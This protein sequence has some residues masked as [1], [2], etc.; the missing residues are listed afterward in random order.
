MKSRFPAS[1]PPARCGTRPLPATRRAALPL[2][3]ALPLL[4]GGLML[5]SEPVRAQATSAI[6]I[7]GRM[8]LAVVHYGGRE[9]INRE[10]NLSSRL[11][12][13]GVEDLGGGYSA[14]FIIETGLSGDTGDSTLGSRETSIGLAGPFGKLRLGYMLNPIDDLHHIAGP[15][16]ATN[17]TN[18]NLSGFWANGYSN[19]FTGGS[20]GSTAC[21]QVAG[22]NGNGNSFAFDNRIGN[23]LR[24]DSPAFSGFKFATQYALGEVGTCHAWASSNKLQYTDDKLNAALA[25]QLHH[26][27]RGTGLQD[28]IWMLVVGYQLTPT[29][30]VAG[31]AQT[32]S[33]ANPGSQDLKQ[34][35]FGL[36]WRTNLDKTNLLELAW[37]RAGAGRGMQTPVFSGIFTGS[38]TASDLYV[39]GARHAFS[40]RTELWMQLAQLRNGKRAGYDLGGAGR[41]G[42]AGT[43][44]ARP[45][46]LALGI[47]H[48]F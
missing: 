7:Y 22:P 23:A 14:Q 36:N 34:N 19:M 47:K 4:A 16:Y 33:Y 46:A 37:Y 12:I 44:A 38:D 18:D 15:G 45:H 29:H 35:G 10:N 48:D 8:N 1:I 9:S 25:Y 41:A 30:Y 39:L 27:V 13:K 20:V 28:H 31:Y 43:T 3:L 6:T 2:L 21:T 40:K 11:G 42:A 24:Y 26:N 17:I 32:L 5:A